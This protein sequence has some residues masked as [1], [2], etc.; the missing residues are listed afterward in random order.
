M[1]ASS[2]QP[3]VTNSMTKSEFQHWANGLTFVKDAADEEPELL[4]AAGMQ[5]MMAWEKP[6][7]ERCVEELSWF[8]PTPWAV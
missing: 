7:M 8:T 3:T 6:L 2:A 5:V 4:D 1:H